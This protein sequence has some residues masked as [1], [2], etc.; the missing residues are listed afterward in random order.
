M[1]HSNACISFEVNHSR[2]DPTQLVG[3]SDDAILE[4]ARSAGHLATSSNILGYFHNLNGLLPY[5]ETMAMCL[6]RDYGGYHYVFLGRDTELLFDAIATIVRGTERQE[7][8]VLMPLSTPLLS[9]IEQDQKHIRQFLEQYLDLEGI[10]HRTKKYLVID[11]GFWGRSI[12]RLNNLVRTAIGM[13]AISSENVHH[14][15]FVVGPLAGILMCFRRRNDKRVNHLVFPQFTLQV[16]PGNYS[17]TDFRGPANIIFSGMGINRA[18]A[19]ASQLMPRHTGHFEILDKFRG[20]PISFEGRTALCAVEE[21][22]IRPT[23]LATGEV[24][25]HWDVPVDPVSAARLQA[26]VVNHFDHCRLQIQQL[27]TRDSTR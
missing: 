5:Y 7:Y 19:S 2:P 25:H 14:D 6:L 27:L 1:Y 15:T 23:T 18:V 4:L 17:D 3:V 12:L 20:T 13:P 10:S 16:D 21:V 8:V 9:T 22:R 11:T 24:I 26:R